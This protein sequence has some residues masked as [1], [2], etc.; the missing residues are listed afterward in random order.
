MYT[1]TASYTYNLHVTLCVSLTP[2]ATVVACWHVGTACGLNCH[3]ECDEVACSV[4][5][6][7]LCSHMH[8]WTNISAVVMCSVT[9]SQFTVTDSPSCHAMRR[10]TS[11]AKLTSGLNSHAY[12]AVTCTRSVQKVRLNFCDC[13][14]VVHCFK[15]EWA[16]RF[17]FLPTWAMSTAHV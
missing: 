1:H 3:A 14:C 4:V 13:P 11:Q 10:F 7:R 6:Q 8:A 9:Y 5:I 16:I 2:G 17:R 15:Q 12:H